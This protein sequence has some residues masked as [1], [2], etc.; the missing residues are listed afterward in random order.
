MREVKSSDA[1][2][3][4]KNKSKTVLILSLISKVIHE[5]DAKHYE[6]IS[7]GKPDYMVSIYERCA[8]NASMPIVSLLN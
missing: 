5:E 4:N 6:Y 7:D 1:R 8:Y 3:D 2:K